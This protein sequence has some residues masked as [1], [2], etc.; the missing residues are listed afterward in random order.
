MRVLILQ[1]EKMF[2]VIGK[3]NLVDDWKQA[4][5]DGVNMKHGIMNNSVSTF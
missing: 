4:I 1:K 5:G 2:T 3:H